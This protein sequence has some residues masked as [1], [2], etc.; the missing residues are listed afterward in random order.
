MAQVGWADDLPMGR[1]E[2]IR[3][4][5]ETGDHA[6]PNADNPHFPAYHLACQAARE[7]NAELIQ[8][9][10]R[11]NLDQGWVLVPFGLAPG[12]T[13]LAAD[14]FGNYAAAASQLLFLNVPSPPPGLG[15]YPARRTGACPLTQATSSPR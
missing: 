8:Q 14:E 13:R 11:R 1:F 5:C 15:G 7:A 3:L 10:I 9:Q 6:L 4:I 12:E 2:H